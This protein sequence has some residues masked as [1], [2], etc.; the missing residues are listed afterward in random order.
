MANESGGPDLRDVWQAQPE[1][2]PRMSTDEIRGKVRSLEQESRRR[3]L[4][5]IACGAVIVPSWL[6]VAW[7]LPDFRLLATVGLL[8]PGFGV[9]WFGTRG[10]PDASL[11]E[12]FAG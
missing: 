4:G 11:P 10:N 1:M 5:L 9:G 3:S 2:E 8:W 12:G 6:A 7:Y